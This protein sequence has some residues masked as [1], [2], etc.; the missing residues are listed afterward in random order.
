[1]LTP[2]SICVF[3]PDGTHVATWK[4][5]ITPEALAVAPDGTIYAA[6]LGKIVKLNEKG[7]ILKSIDSPHLAELPPLPE[8][9]DKEETEED[10]VAKEAKIKELTEEMKPLQKMLSDTYAEL[11][12]AQKAEDQDAVIRIQA[13]I[14]KVSEQYR[15]L[16][17]Q[18]NALRIDKKALIVQQRNDAMQAR[19]VKSIA[20]TDDDIFL[21]C[22]P[23]K[24]YASVVWR[25]DKNFENGEVIVKNLSGCCG[26]M[27]IAAVDGKLVVPENGRKKVNVYERDGT[28]LYTWGE[29]ERDDELAG[30]GSCCNPMNVTFDAD[31]NILTSEASVGA[32]K[33]YTKDGKFLEYVALSKIV[34]GCK[35]TPIG[36]SKDGNTVYMLDLTQA[37]VIVMQK[38]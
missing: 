10:K 22:P 32:V 12:K 38:P 37:Q 6:G 28:K 3:T 13:D 4:L 11:L 15:N 20:A 14:E 19:S 31:G 29:D 17:S 9:D 27:N 16:F 7:E 23:V 25:L 8:V 5:E 30:F 33:R 21:C 34:P 2:P 26:Q 1:V 18:V 36:I 35:H 24:G